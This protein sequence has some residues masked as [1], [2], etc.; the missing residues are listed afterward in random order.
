MKQNCV[1]FQ[2][3]CSPAIRNVPPVCW[4]CWHVLQTLM[5]TCSPISRPSLTLL[6]FFWCRRMQSRSPLQ[7][8]NIGK[9]DIRN[10]PEEDTPLPDIT[11]LIKEE[12]KRPLE[13]KLDFLEGE[14]D[15]IQLRQSSVNLAGFV[16]LYMRDLINIV[17]VRVGSTLK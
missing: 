14:Y 2:P 10:I 6:I 15:T 5:N 4:Q 17:K 8:G 12:S 7:T 13:T 11:L 3:K 1:D 9:L 16:S